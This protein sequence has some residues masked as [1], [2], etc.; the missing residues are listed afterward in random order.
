[1]GVILTNKQHAVKW[2]FYDPGSGMIV[3]WLLIYPFNEPPEAH[4]G[5]YCSMAP[6]CYCLGGSMLYIWMRHCLCVAP[7]KLWWTITEQSPRGSSSNH[8]FPGLLISSSLTHWDSGQHSLDDCTDLRKGPPEIWVCSRRRSRG[9]AKSDPMSRAEMTVL[10]CFF[11][12]LFLTL[13]HWCETNTCIEFEYLCRAKRLMLWLLT[14][15]EAE[16]KQNRHTGGR[17]QRKYTH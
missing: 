17:P 16:R 11:S 14:F 3:S 1:M 12:Q 6:V 9:Q 7:G 8:G 2:R 10:S 13:N 15:R 5:K 4:S